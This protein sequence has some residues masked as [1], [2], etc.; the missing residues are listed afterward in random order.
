MD[1]V[2]LLISGDKDFGN[3][4]GR[5]HNAPEIAKLIL[6]RLPRDDGT[7]LPVNRNL[8]FNVDH[9]IDNNH[10]TGFALTEFIDCK[11]GI[12]CG[13][14]KH[15]KYF[16]HD[17]HYN[18]NYVHQN[19][20]ATSASNS[21]Q[22]PTWSISNTSVSSDDS[23]DELE[24]IDMSDKTLGIRS[25]IP[26]RHGNNCWN[27]KNGNCHF[28]HPK[29][30]NAASRNKRPCRNGN[31]CEHWKQ[32]HCIWY[33]ASPYSVPTPPPNPT[34]DQPQQLNHQQQDQD[35]EFVCYIPPN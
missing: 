22:S 21:Y 2:V 11:D 10:G 32:G 20:P 28:L 3:I 25:T 31:D 5:I 17:M 35:V 16:H 7:E 15:C 12:N 33:H 1:L 14:I 18:Y 34:H 6:V 19:S 4:L 30:Y 9:I 24:D 23:K 13:H 8:Y 27:W 26:C 29:A